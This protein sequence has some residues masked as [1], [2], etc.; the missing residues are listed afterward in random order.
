MLVAGFRADSRGDGV[1]ELMKNEVE[2]GRLFP[3]V[4]RGRLEL[5]RQFIGSVAGALTSFGCRFIS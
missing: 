4:F 3:I 5:D 1:F 2:I